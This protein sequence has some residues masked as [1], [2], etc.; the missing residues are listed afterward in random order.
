[1]WQ[2]RSVNT[3]GGTVNLRYRP[4]EVAYQSATPAPGFQVDV[5]KPGPPEVK[6]EFESESAKVAIEASW[7]G[8]DIRIDLSTEDEHEG[9]DEEDH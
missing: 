9:E 3:A 6:V 4:G 1:M 5:E 2:T 7:D 8:G